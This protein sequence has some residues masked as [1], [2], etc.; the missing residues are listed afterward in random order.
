VEKPE[1]R[2][3]VNAGI[4]AVS[5][6]CL[7]LIPR[8]GFFTMPDLMSALVARGEKVGVFPIAGFWRGLES[9]ENFDEAFAYL[10]AQA[11]SPAP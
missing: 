11:P 3:S 4:Y 1:R 9:R 6:R 10:N 8:G 7:D 5:G 2:E